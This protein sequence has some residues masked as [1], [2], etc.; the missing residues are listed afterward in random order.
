MPDL[1]VIGATGL[2]GATTAVEAVRRGWSVRALVRSADVEPLVAAGVEVVRGDVADRAGLIAAMDGVDA[3][4]NCAALLGGSWVRAT[5]EQ[6]WQTNHDGALN[7]FDAAAGAGVRRCVHLD[8][9]SIWRSDVTMTESGP[10]LPPGPNDSPYVQA[11]RAAYAGAVH[12]MTRGQDI[13]F[14][15]PG[16]IY[17][18]GLFPDRVLDPTSFTRLALRGIRGE[19]DSF[20]SFPMAWT[21]APDLADVILGAVRAGQRGQRFLAMGRPEDVSS[22]AAFCNAAAAIAGVD[23]RVRDIDPNAD[24]APDVGSMRQFAIRRYA[25]PLMDDS[26]TRALLS[27]VPTARHDALRRTV[28]WLREHGHL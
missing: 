27:V 15:T 6:M 25:D 16:A 11:K 13:V 8:S 26:A 21:F 3:V 17:G 28:D 18:P 23:F 22:L 4:V 14:V 20:I 9:N 10:M 19:L 24:D 1:L 7:V 2:T 12:R 5:P